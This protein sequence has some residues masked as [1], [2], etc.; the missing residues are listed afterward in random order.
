[1]NCLKMGNILPQIDYELPRVAGNQRHLNIGIYVKRQH[2]TEVYRCRVKIKVHQGTVIPDLESVDG[3]V[4]DK[5]YTAKSGKEIKR[6][7]KKIHGKIIVDVP[8]RGFFGIESIYG[9]IGNYL[10]MVEE[11]G[12]NKQ[13]FIAFPP[14]FSMG[15]LDEVIAK[16][17]FQKLF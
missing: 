1:M 9:A 15:S 7:P 12:K 13:F 6:Y 2:E 3:V 10:K 17:R 4:L 11:G 5:L 16:L 14:N 8:E